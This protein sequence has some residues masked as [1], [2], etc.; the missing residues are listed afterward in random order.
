[1]LS[2]TQHTCW[3]RAAKMVA[4][5]GRERAERDLKHLLALVVVVHT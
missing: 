3:H 4:F 2:F 1:M 5:D